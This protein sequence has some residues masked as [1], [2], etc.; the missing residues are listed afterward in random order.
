MNNKEY[1]ELL[2]D[3]DKPLAIYRVDNGFD[4]FTDFSK[5]VKLTEKN[6][7][8]FFE[9]IVRK[10]NYKNK[11]FDGYIGF[12]SYELQCKLINI[13]LPKQKSNGFKESFF[14][15]PETLIKIR[16]KDQGFSNKIYSTKSN[17]AREKNIF[18]SN[19]KFF[20][21]K[22]FKVNL[23]LNDYKKNI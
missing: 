22:N 12:L 3:S 1:L 18:V 20:Y 11:F 19:K 16:K 8:L 21:E 14:Y 4:I 23:S 9:K 15:K 5:K 6:A 10:K 13:K 2:Y 7:K 17:K